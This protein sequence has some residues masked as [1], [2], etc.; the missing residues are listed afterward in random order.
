LHKVTCIK[1]ALTNLG[2]P[3]LHDD[4]YL[5]PSDV[6]S[7]GSRT[8]AGYASTTPARKLLAANNG[9]N[10]V[11]KAVGLIN[12]TVARLKAAGA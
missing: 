10:R 9:I 12:G 7:Q 4:A 3:Q 2:G 1:N 6:D 8:L 5:M 11:A